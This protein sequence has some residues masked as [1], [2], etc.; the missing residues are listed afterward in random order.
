MSSH[1]DNLGKVAQQD[2]ASLEVS[3]KEYGSS[4]KRRGGVGAYMMLARKWDR[5]EKAVESKYGFDIFRAIEED[6]RPEGVIDDI[7]D[8][9]RYLMLVESEMIARGMVR[10]D[11]K[12]TGMEQPF[13]YNAEEEIGAQ[14]SVSD[15][16]GNLRR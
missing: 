1:I 12:S 15:G 16:R 4:W 7:R 14:I 11:V 2:V 9:R 10:G 3:E 8:L 6:A 5:L 13:G